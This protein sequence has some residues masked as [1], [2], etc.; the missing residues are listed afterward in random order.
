MTAPDP[1]RVSVV[2][3]VYDEGARLPG[4]AA[5]LVERL[6]DLQGVAVETLVVDDGSSAAD[7][8][9]CRRATDAAARR[10]RERGTPH[11]FRFVRAAR[12]GG[13][14]HA[15]RLGWEHVD[16]AAAWMG[17]IDGDGAVSAAELVRLIGMLPTLDPEIAV[18]AGS[19]VKMAGRRIDR[20][21][22]RHFQGRVFATI[23]ET[24]LR[25]GVYDTQCG[26]KLIRA[27]R[28]RSVLPALQE[29]GW[30]LDVEVFALLKAR[31]A[32]FLE[33][34]ID[35]VDAGTSKVRFGID[36]LRMLCALGRIRGR[37]RRTL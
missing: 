25:L 8:E 32:R 30:M 15:I 3:P 31:G 17:W 28:L 26:V 36:P 37:A 21:A 19:R 18:V 33:V 35:W 16:P 4:L 13:K 10:L 1:L 14:G 24:W 22:F 2:V 6:P 11:T 23:A 7:S 12:N 5:S 20:R 27:D 9:S 34:P 29:N